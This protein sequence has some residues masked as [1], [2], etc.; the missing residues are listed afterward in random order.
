MPI[1]TRLEERLGEPIPWSYRRLGPG[2]QEASRAF[3]LPR[4][5]RQKLRD[6][7]GEL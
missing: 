4:P 2:E 6:A 3:E 7:L 1:R 5:A